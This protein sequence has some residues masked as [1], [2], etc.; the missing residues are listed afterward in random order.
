MGKSG[1]ST[2][3][4]GIEIANQPGQDVDWTL[5]SISVEQESKISAAGPIITLHFKA[6]VTL[7]DILPC[8]LFSP[9]WL[10]R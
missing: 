10:P 6:I 9:L 4:R 8:K 2:G 1:K 7:K 3:N 5:W